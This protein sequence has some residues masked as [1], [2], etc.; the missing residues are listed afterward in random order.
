TLGDLELKEGDWVA[1]NFAAASRDP[2]ITERPSEVD[3]HRED[4][5]HPAFGVGAH[6]CLGSHLARLEMKVTLE[7][8]LRRIPQYNLTPGTAPVT[9][10]SQLR[11]TT[12]LDITFP[13]GGKGGA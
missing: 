10:T 7:E 4:V 8:F 2:E 6:R 5:I 11:T 3:I 9:E 12:S 1:L 13:A